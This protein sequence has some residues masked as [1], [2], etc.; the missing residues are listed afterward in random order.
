MRIH[1]MI[2]DSIVDGPGLRFVVFVQGCLHRCAACHNPETH[3]VRGGQEIAAEDVIADMLRNPLTDGVTLSGGEPFA[4][5]EDCA[6]IARAAREAGLNV[7]CYTGYT[8]EQLREMP[9]TEILLC[10]L[11]VL[12][13]GPFIAAQKNLNLT[14]RG[15]ENQRVIQMR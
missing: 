6:K 11:D 12:V 13:D 4:Q 9:E 1:R 14:W 7:W 2:Q 15:S 8:L 10:E 5:A 3:D